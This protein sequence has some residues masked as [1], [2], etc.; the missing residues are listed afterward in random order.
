MRRDLRGN[1]TVTG[2]FNPRTRKG[3]DDFDAVEFSRWSVSI[4][5]PVKDATNYDLFNEKLNKFQSTHP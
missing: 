3:C 4:H 5:A 1:E 2:G